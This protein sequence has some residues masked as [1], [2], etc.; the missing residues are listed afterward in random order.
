MIRIDDET[1][2]APKPSRVKKPLTVTLPPEFIAK[3]DEQK[4]RE[5]RSASEIVREALRLYYGTGQVSPISPMSAGR[6]PAQKT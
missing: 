4:V 5:N 3:I 1:M 6:H 2:T